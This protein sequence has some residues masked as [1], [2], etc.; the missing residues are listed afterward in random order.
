[1]FWLVLVSMW[2]LFLVIFN[3]VWMWLMWVCFLVILDFIMW[4][5][6]VELLCVVKVVFYEMFVFRCGVVGLMVKFMC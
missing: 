5:L 6:V 3:W 2:V 4:G 1:M